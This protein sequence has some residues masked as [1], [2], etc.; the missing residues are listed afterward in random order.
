MRSLLERLD[1]HPEVQSFF[2]PY[3][4]TA[5]GTLIFGYGNAY[6][7]AGATF[8]KVPVTEEFWMAGE[9]ALAT[10]LFICGAAM[11]AIAWL[12]LN[13]RRYSD[14]ENLCFMSIGSVPHKSHAEIIQPYTPNKKLH[15]IFS[16]DDLGAVCDLRLASM[17]RNKPLKIT[18][19][20]H[21]FKVIFEHKY[22]EFEKLSLHALERVGGYNFRIR[23]HKPQKASTYY[24]QTRNSYLP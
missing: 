16:K 13:H 20:N 19:H 21:L 24:E 9:P 5:C 12:N 8:H 14:P 15:F 17:I 22:Y 3:L 7:H 2:K 6:E 18:H 11:D 1:I 4:K 10:T 23:T